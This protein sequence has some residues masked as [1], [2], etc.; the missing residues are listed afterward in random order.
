MPNGRTRWRAL[1]APSGCTTTAAPGS[2]SRSADD[3]LALLRWQRCPGVGTGE[4]P[5]DLG[6]HVLAVDADGRWLGAGEPDVAS[7]SIRC[8]PRKSNSA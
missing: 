5:G 3:P 8:L 4:C 1:S 2:R 6:E 7:K